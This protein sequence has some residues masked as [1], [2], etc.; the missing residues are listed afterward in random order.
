MC[1]PWTTYAK[2]NRADLKVLNRQLFKPHQANQY[3]EKPKSLEAGKT[4]LLIAD[5]NFRT[6]KKST[7]RTT[8]YFIRYSYHM[9]LGFRILVSRRTLRGLGLEEIYYCEFLLNHIHYHVYNS[10]NF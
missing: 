2:G 6:K 4:Y 8:S 9:L 7:E 3:K 10:I 5:S 1:V